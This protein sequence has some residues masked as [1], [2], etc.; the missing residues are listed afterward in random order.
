MSNALDQHTINVDPPTWRR[1]HVN[2]VQS[3]VEADAAKTEAEEGDD[4]KDIA[5]DLRSLM[6]DDLLGAPT[7]MWNA[8]RHHE[9]Y[10][11]RPTK[12]KND[13]ERIRR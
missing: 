5:A 7:P 2:A 8:C 4:L 3:M 6:D 13:N 10:R 1:G 12:E 9:R 11:Y